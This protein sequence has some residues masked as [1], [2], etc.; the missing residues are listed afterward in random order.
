MTPQRDLIGYG[1][2][3]PQGTWP[4]GA[5]LAINVVVNYEEGS[6]RSLAMG[7]PDQESM[8]EWGSYVTPPDT[9]NLAMESM[10]E[11][12][13]RVGIWRIL[14]ILRD[15]GV[16]ATLF[17]CAVALEQ[18]P[19]VARR[20]AEDGHEFCSH[21]YRWEEVF[22]LSEDEEREHIR[23]AIK[24]ITK[25]TGKRPVGWYCRYG[26][27]VHTRRLLVEEGGF[28]Y[29]SD[30]Y[31]DDVP[32]FTEVQGNRHLV[33]PYTTDTNDFRFW[34]SPGI[35][36]GREFLDYLKESF[37][38][39]LEE[40]AKGPRMMSIGLHP[41]MVGRPGKIGALKA[42]IEHAQQHEGVW[43]TTREDIAKAWLARE[44]R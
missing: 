5:R 19:A 30:A 31:N 40:A 44:G 17:A 32:Y 37:E 14:N 7:D 41:R 15:T 4:N 20:A 27:S 29:D 38:V 9:R 34:L 42:F 22:R 2:A 43:F 1:E 8:T 28:L 23:L 33:V 16:P 3:P 35:S 25:S 12:G 13:S 21:G 36:S 39:L 6:E 18:N 10:Y 11:Y 24:S 26:P